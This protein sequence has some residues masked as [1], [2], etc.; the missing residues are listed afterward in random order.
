MNEREMEVLVAALERLAVAFEALGS[1][2]GAAG[3]RWPDE[4]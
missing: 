3:L 4:E 2:Q 1:N